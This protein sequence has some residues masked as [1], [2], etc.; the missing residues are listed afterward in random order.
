MSLESAPEGST[1]PA[2]RI[3][4]CES[5]ATALAMPFPGVKTRRP[6]PLKEESRSPSAASAAPV[7]AIRAPEITAAAIP[8][9][10]GWVK[11]IA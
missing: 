9:P 2:S 5:T 10:L 8:P 4:P 1:A 3:L 6:S 11:R 7:Q